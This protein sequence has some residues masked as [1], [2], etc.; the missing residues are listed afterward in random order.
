M[1]VQVRVGAARL[2]E[3]P[4]SRP[5][6]SAIFKE[7]VS[8]P[9]RLGVLGLEGDQVADKRHH[10][11]LNQAVLAYASEHYLLWREE[12]IDA[13]LGAFGEN[14]LMSGLR[15][16]D[17]AIGDIFSVGE[18]L[19]QVSHPRQPCNTLARRFGRND[20]VPRVW[21]KARGGWYMR[22]LREGTVQAGQA[23]VLQERL[24]PG[25]TVARVLHA[26]QHAAGIPEE[27]L[28]AARVVGLTESWVLKLQ[29]KAGV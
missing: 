7:P 24:N 15:D 13:D 23:V 25:W 6:R 27:A 18:T 9:V 16:Q 1:L 10:G 2:I 22:V 20:I 11:G 17:V 19:V 21:A 8:G 14:F 29:E 3:G 28:A 4:L 12:G 5:W 26:Y